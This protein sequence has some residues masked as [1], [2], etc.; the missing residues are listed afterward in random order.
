MKNNSYKVILLTTA[1]LT[2]SFASMNVYASLT[3]T[4]ISACIKNDGSVKIVTA[5]S[6][7]A[8][9]ESLLVWNITGPKGEKGD[10]GSQG[11]PGEVGTSTPATHG[12]GNIAFVSGGALLK[13]DGTVWM[14]GINS[15]YILVDG[16]NFS[17]V[18]N[19]PVA[20]EDILVWEYTRVL[21]KNGNYW[22]ISLS[23]IQAGWKNLGQLP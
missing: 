18:T 2:V 23:N 13:T 19:I 20:I 12:V 3:N 4:Q 9:N 16:V 1:I 15:A 22:V 6:T 21:D 10:A 11:I 7:C 17:G 5:S 8:K 14:S